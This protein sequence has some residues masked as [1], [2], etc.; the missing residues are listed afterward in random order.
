MKKKAKWIA[1]ALLCV[2]AV[3]FTVLVLTVDRQPIA[4]NGSE[5]GFASFNQKAKDY[6]R[7]ND[8]WYQVTGILGYAALG[9]AA[10][11]ALLGLWQWIRRRSL[12]KVDPKLFCLGGLYVL[13]GALYLLFEKAVVNM[14]PVLED[15]KAEASFPSSHTVLACVIFFSAV[16]FLE[17]YVKNG[18][19]RSILSLV[20]GA[21]VGASVV[22]RLLSGVHW[23]TDIIGGVLYSAALLALFIAAIASLP[24]PKAPEKSETKE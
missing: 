21:A 2:I 15:G 14:R 9:L 11:F 1:A 8:A 13:T 3:V 7:T 23:A 19:L 24:A 12:K 10:L 4:V 16:F 6:I 22:G 5:V 18:V 20:L 17:D